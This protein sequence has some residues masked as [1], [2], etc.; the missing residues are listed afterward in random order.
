VLRFILFLIALLM[1]E[2]SSCEKATGPRSPW[3]A[4]GL[5]SDYFSQ[6]VTTDRA[7]YCATG[8][9]GVY[10]QKPACTGPWHSL[11]LDF[12]EDQFISY[13]LGVRTVLPL[14]QG[15]IL[16]GVWNIS[17]QDTVNIFR[18][19]PLTGSWNPS[20]RGMPRHI[21]YDLCAVEEGTILAVTSGGLYS[22]RDDGHSWELIQFAQWISGMIYR[23]PTRIYV[24]GE[25][26]IYSS[27]Y[28][29]SSADGVSNWIN[30]A[31]TGK[32]PY[33][34]EGI[35]GISALE[36]ANELFVAT[37]H[38]VFR[39]ENGGQDFVRILDVTCPTTVDATL[40]KLVALGDSVYI[41]GDLGA[42]WTTHALPGACFGRG[43]VDWV[44]NKALLPVLE[45]DGG[46]L[47]S[48]E[49][50]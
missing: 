6:I 38:H 46:M 32:I 39:S 12:L 34:R 48:F 18:Y 29:L 16:A 15:G 41:S 27:P 7:L 9:F 28:L 3:R 45:H 24:G 30:L 21:V 10:E 22:S 42:T 25:T 35:T 31:I 47:Y 40:D 36:E 1:L 14:P 20:N 17:I 2:S 49:L 23:S 43:G 19:D 26:T 13:D 11:G 50:E 44:T 4:L 8:V 37:E 33:N 5:E